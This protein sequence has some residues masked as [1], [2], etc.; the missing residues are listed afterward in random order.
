M[1]NNSCCDYSIKTPDYGQYVCPKHVELNVKIKLIN[2]ASFL[3]LLYE[4]ITIN[5][6]PISNYFFFTEF[7]YSNFGLY[8]FIA[9]IPI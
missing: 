9:P 8:V 5:C 1:T 6:P 2:S 4:Y 3:F 7:L